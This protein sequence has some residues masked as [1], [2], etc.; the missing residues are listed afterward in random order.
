MTLQEMFD[1]LVDLGGKLHI[2][3]RQGLTPLTMAAMLAR[4][5]ASGKR[6]IANYY[7]VIIW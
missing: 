4:K 3:N 7:H 5:E 2:K 6:Q 1:L